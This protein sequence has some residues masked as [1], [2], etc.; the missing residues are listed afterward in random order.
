MTGNNGSNG[1]NAVDPAELFV[2]PA[3]IRTS[4]NGS[5]VQEP[6]YV[7]QTRWNSYL[8][9]VGAQAEKGHT[10]YDREIIDS[11]GLRTNLFRI[12]NAAKGRVSSLARKESNPGLIAERMPDIN[13]IIPEAVPAGA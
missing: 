12:Y 5:R 1:Y 4:I 10:A 7:T 8:Q 9:F 13:R 6:V 3:F 11:Q 2:E